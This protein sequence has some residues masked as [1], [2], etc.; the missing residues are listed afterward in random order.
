[1]PYRTT[2]FVDGDYYHIFNRG[3]AKMPIFKDYRYYKRFI[4]SMVY[5]QTE[6]PKPKFSVFNPEIHKIEWNKKMVDMIC[7][8]LMPNHLHI[9]LRQLRAGGITEFM[10]KLPDSYT[11]FFNTK[12]SRVGPIF[13]GM[14]KAVRVES[15]EQL[16]HVSRYIHLNPLVSGLVEAMDDY[17]WSSYPEYMGYTDMNICEKDIIL[18]Q[19]KLKDGYQ[20]FILDQEAYGRELEFIKH[21]LLDI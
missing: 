19:F 4:K 12:N 11:K 1:M 6:G 18:E 9:L 5:Y 10:K 13:Q 17:K 15:N 3:V 7:Y 8:C 21:Q 16:L 2:P 20:N 14:F